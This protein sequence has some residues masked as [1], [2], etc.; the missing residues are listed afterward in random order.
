M[1]DD[2]TVRLEPHNPAWAEQAAQ[3]SD[4]WHAVLGP[5]L[6]DCHHI[7]STSV[8]GL[9]AKPV[10]DIMPEVT[11]LPPLDT[12]RDVVE[13]MGYE[14]MGEFGLPGRRYCRI[15]TAN[16]AH[17]I[18]AHAYAHGNPAITRHL[19]FRDY[20]RTHPDVAAEYGQI[21]Q[22]CAAQHA[23]DRYAYGDCKARWIQQTESRALK[24]Y[25]Q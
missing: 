23:D 11:A 21:K 9:V 7:G 2:M 1:T 17:L 20:L 10:I 3:E 24:E 25:P 16:G 22:T 19:A 12:L 8:P 6:L 15:L 5:V 14:W 4:R 18:H 13:Q